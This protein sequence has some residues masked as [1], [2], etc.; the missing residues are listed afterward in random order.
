MSNLQ[1]LIGE[2]IS[3][4][5]K[6]LRIS[7]SELA[8]K[9][10]KSLRTVQK[11]ES[12]EIDMPI[13]V[14]QE[15]S[16]ILKVPINYLI[17]YDSSHIKLET[18]ADVYAYLFELDRKKELNFDIEIIKEPDSVRKAALVFELSTANYNAEMFNML[19]RLKNNKEALSTYWMDYQTF[20]AWEKSVIENTNGEFLSDKE[21]EILD[22]ISLIEKRNEAERKRM[23][24]MLAKQQADNSD[25]SEQ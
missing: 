2:R 20:D 5:R 6:K 18:L 14:L 4:Q 13:S 9:L 16:D 25:D 21:R 11:Y 24:E 7:Q 12:G 19:Q 23:E 8:E 10:G 15:I 3:E 17:G 22:E 1:A